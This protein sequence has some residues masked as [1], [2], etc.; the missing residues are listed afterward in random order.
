VAL[1]FGTL[2]A[3]LVPIGNAVVVAVLAALAAGGLVGW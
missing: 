3:A 2:A 1:P